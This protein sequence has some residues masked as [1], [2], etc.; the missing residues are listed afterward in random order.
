MRHGGCERRD[1]AVRGNEAWDDGTA[2]AE[3]RDYEAKVVADG[4]A[5]PSGRRIARDHLAATDR[6][7]ALDEPCHRHIEEM[8][9]AVRRSDLAVLAHDN[10]RVKDAAIARIHALLLEATKR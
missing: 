3:A 2:V 8:D 4:H 1:G 9:L 6:L 10:M 5:E 7:L